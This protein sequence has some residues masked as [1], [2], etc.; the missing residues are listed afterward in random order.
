MK[1]ILFDFDGT[2]ANSYDFVLDF[3]LRESKHRHNADF[4]RESMRHL[5]MLT[6]ARRLGIAWW[7][8]PGLLTRGRRAMRRH[9]D[10]VELFS[11]MPP[12]IRELRRQ[13]YRMMILSSNIEPSIHE[14]LREYDIDDYFDDV[15]GKV[16]MFGKGPALRKLLAKHKLEAHDCVYIG[17][18]VRDVGSSEVVGVECIAVTWGFADPA[19]LRKLKTFAVV[20][21]VDELRAAIDTF[22]AK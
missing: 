19:V 10:T 1:T 2:I 20:D 9:L 22:N 16:G 11:G 5:S 6:M 7:R 8:L 12:L 17:D 13:G 3:L 18:E 4:D 14:F 21:T 15:R